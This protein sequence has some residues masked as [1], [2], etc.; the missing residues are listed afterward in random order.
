MSGRGAGQREL[1]SCVRRGAGQQQEVSDLFHCI[2][3]PSSIIC[4]LFFVVVNISLLVQ[5]LLPYIV[6]VLSLS[7]NIVYTVTLQ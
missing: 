1:M 7:Q 6:G 3:R 2:G 4:L 5:H